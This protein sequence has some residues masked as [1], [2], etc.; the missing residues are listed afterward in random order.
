[1]PFSYSFADH[2][3]H[4]C[5]EMALLPVCL[6][7]CQI[8]HISHM[9]NI[10]ESPMQARLHST[11]SCNHI[12]GPLTLLGPSHRDSFAT[13]PGPEALVK[14]RMNITQLLYSCILHDSKASITWTTVDT[15]KW[16]VLL[17]KIP[18]PFSVYTFGYRISK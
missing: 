6:F 3:I 16:W 11:D 17:K 14:S 5:L 7:P 12:L 13:H 1:M 8:Y 15:C 18:H 9:N 4:H 10:L 2:K